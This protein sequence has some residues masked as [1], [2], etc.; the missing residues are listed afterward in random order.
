MSYL[1]RIS[2]LPQIGE[3]SQLAR[4]LMGNQY[5]MHRLLW[6]LFP[7][8]DGEA[9]DFLF[10]E[11]QYTDGRGRKLPLFYLVSPREPQTDS[12]LFQID[13]KLYQPD[14]NAG[15]R[16]AFM[17]RANPVISRKNGGQR[18]RSHDVAMD[19]QH[20]CLTQLCQQAGVSTEGPKR[21]RIKRL[22]ALPAS[23]LQT[24]IQGYH[25]AVPASLSALLKLQQQQAL[26]Q[27]LLQRGERNGFQL[28]EGSHLQQTACRWNALPEK[29][30]GKNRRQAGFTSVDFEGVL[31]VTEP[32]AF[33]T[34][35]KQ[36][37]GKARA[38]GC[39]LMM[40]RRI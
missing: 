27:W 7:G 1:S 5:G 11:E 13:S 23:Q 18:S 33:T 2:L 29:D 35:L 30:R 40:V 25:P 4:L 22:D 17:L 6:D 34:M 24:L 37:L 21:A 9:R 12:P 31:T 10:R 19:A 15:D 16:L 3:Q 8:R 28:D 32:E 26:Q 14:L 20:Q 36:G 38:F 39:G